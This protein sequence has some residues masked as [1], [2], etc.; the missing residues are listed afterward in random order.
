MFSGTTSEEADLTTFS[1]ITD[2]NSSFPPDLSQ[3]NATLRSN[4]TIDH[5][6]NLN[7]THGGSNGSFGSLSPESSGPGSINSGR[8]YHENVGECLSRLFLNLDFNSDGDCD[9]LLSRFSNFDINYWERDL[10]RSIGRVLLTLPNDT[11]IIDKLLGIKLRLY[12]IHPKSQLIQNN[13][14]TPDDFRISFNGEG[15]G[16]HILINKDELRKIPRTFS[17]VAA[18]I[19]PSLWQNNNLSSVSPAKPVESIQ[20][21]DKLELNKMFHVLPSNSSVLSLSV[22]VNE[23]NSRIAKKSV[24]I[25]TVNDLKVTND[26]YLQVERKSGRVIP[27]KAALSHTCSFLNLENGLDWSVEGCGLIH[28]DDQAVTCGCNHTTSF[29]V[30]LSMRTINIPSSISTVLTILE[31]ISILALVLTLVLL[32]WL[33]KSIRNDRTFVQINLSLSLLLLHLFFLLGGTD[34]VKAIPRSCK[35]F[36]VLS[37]FFSLSSAFWMLNEGI[38]LY[39]KISKQALSFSMK[40]ILPVL[41][42]IAWGM[43]IIIVIISA[44]IGFSSDTYLDEQPFGESMYYNCWLSVESK[45]IL[46]VVIPLAVV[47]CVTTLIITKVA[48]CIVKMS[49]NMRKMKPSVKKN[50]LSITDGEKEMTEIKRK[51]KRTQTPTVRITPKHASDAVRA[52]LLLLPVLGI[53]WILSFLVNIENAEEVFIIIHGII[54]GLQGVFILFI[55]CVKNSQFRRSFK[56]KLSQYSSGNSLLI[57]VVSQSGSN[58]KRRS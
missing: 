1:T 40:N 25:K 51:K 34:S 2:L 8:N 54:N 21:K 58:L 46:A 9:L 57:R 39:V 26:L 35:A 52:V 43:P 38:V 36:A 12:R 11:F 31:S 24:S 16:N 14:S 33:K 53:P 6:K 45:M 28:A 13:S 49:Q 22:F 30:I 18:E 20:K 29:G 44:A 55:Y 27:L 17:I 42:L 41:V 10:S 4:S 7:T 47:F 37:H 5:E 23:T 32:L 15:V 56:H 48:F 50:Q 3:P 19:Q